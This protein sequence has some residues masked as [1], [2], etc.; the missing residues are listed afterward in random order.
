MDVLTRPLSQR[1]RPVHILRCGY[2]AGTLSVGHSRA[3]RPRPVCKFVWS[4]CR[5]SIVFA[6]PRAPPSSFHGVSGTGASDTAHGTRGG[7]PASGQYSRNA[8][9][10]LRARFAS[11]GQAEAVPNPLPPIGFRSMDA[12]RAPSGD[13]SPTYD[14]ASEPVAEVPAPLLPSAT[15]C[16]RRTALRALIMPSGG[17]SLPGS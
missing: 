2:R 15:Q 8:C 5:L 4:A 17:S 10:L 14:D 16:P 6:C 12:E 1:V 11:L 7:S 13:L 3:T 9:P